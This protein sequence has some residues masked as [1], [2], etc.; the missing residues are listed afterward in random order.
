MS[1]NES[2]ILNTGCRGAASARNTVFIM[3]RHAQPVVFTAHGHSM[4]V[5][6]QRFGAALVAGGKATEMYYPVA[7]FPNPAPPSGAHRPY[8]GL[9]LYGEFA[10][11][12]DPFGLARGECTGG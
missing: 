1:I 8:H 9:P 10:L 6:I 5:H 3:L 12:G 4:I 2:Q 11:S 7:A